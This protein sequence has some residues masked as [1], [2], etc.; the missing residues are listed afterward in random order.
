M[1]NNFVLEATRREITGKLVKKLRAQGIIPGV[2][3]GPAFEAVPFQVE[4]AKLRPVLQE[5]GGSQVIEVVLGDKSY[6]ALVRE[7]QRDSIRGDVLH[8]DFYRVRM[9]VAIRT[10]VPIALTNDELI[11]SKGGLVNQELNSVEVECLPTDLPAEIVVDLSSLQEIGERVT[12]GQLPRF[13]GVT[14]LMDD[15]VVVV[16]T[17]YMS[18]ITEE[19]EEGEEEIL[20]EGT[21]E[22]ELIRKEHEDEDED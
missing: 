12:V 15:D 20:P 9:D 17:Q 19:E 2:L 13:E 5:A 7:V 1:A 8:V 6:H 10:E 16:S 18:Q 22:P 11:L 14:Y 3:Y 4:W 21:V